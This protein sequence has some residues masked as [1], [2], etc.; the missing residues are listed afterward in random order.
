M[1]NT[2][3]DFKN[4]DEAFSSIKQITALTYKEKLEFGQITFQQVLTDTNKNNLR[5]AASYY[6]DGIN[7]VD[8][9]K[10]KVS[11][12]NALVLFKKLADTD[13]GSLKNN[14]LD[15]IVSLHEEFNELEKTNLKPDYHSI[16]QKLKEIVSIRENQRKK[17]PTD[18]TLIHNLANNY[19]DLAYYSLY[20]KEFQ[21]AIQYAD[22][23]LK[24]EPAY[25][26]IYTNLALGYLLSKE[27]H[28]NEAKNLYEKYKNIKMIY[29]GRSFKEGFLQDFEDL[30]N[31]GI[32]SKDDKRVER[33]KKL[34]NDK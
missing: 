15:N 26:I 21:N 22:T 3:E 2:G 6:H 29:D 24:V 16:L 14:D 4:L 32:I 27:D 12:G 10:R 13:T 11:I 34:L 18:S 33:I 1:W 31:A 19:N 25:D 8:N 20:T 7:E 30:T 17:Y 5:T 28:F 9:N 23:G